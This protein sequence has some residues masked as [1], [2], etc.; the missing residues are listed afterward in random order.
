MH[1]FFFCSYDFIFITLD[2][3][4]V[5]I[6]A[7]SHFDLFMILLFLLL[8][9]GI[10]LI[11]I[12]WKKIKQM[13]CNNNESVY[14]PIWILY[15]SNITTQNCST[16]K[17]IKTNY[18]CS[19]R[20]FPL[21]LSNFF[22]FLVSFFFWKKKKKKSFYFHISIEFSFF[23]SFVSLIFVLLQFLQFTCLFCVFFLFHHW[24]FSFICIN[25]TKFRMLF[26]YVYM[27]VLSRFLYKFFYFN[28]NSF[29]LFNFFFFFW[30]HLHWWAIDDNTI[31]KIYVF[32]CLCIN[33]W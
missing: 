16:T 10:K 7:L 23:S 6:F 30:Y 5:A 9:F 18:Q 3:V 26:I 15:S 19:V 32:V 1:V 31:H 24:I 11:Y 27:F 22:H 12:F 29:Y 2:I 8:L 14:A 20:I 33:A 28:L 21:P 17:C 13:K 25:L 4:F